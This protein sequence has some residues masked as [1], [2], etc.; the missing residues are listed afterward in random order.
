VLA[1]ALVYELLLEENPT[2]ASARYKD[3]EM[4]LAMAKESKPAVMESVEM[5]YGGIE[6]GEFGHW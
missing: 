2:V 4:A 3:F 1:P 5:P 6:Y